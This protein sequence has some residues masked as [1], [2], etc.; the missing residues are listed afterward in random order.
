MNGITLDELVCVVMVYMAINVTED[1]HICMLACIDV[2][3]IE[4]SQTV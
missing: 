2:V 4:T 3:V 1:P